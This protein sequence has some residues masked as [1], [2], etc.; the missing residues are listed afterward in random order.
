MQVVA[1]AHNAGAL[2]N[3]RIQYGLFTG[4]VT[5][6]LL[7][8]ESHYR[9]QVVCSY[10]TDDGDGDAIS[11]CMFSCQLTAEQRTEELL[12]LLAGRSAVRECMAISGSRAATSLLSA[13]LDE[14]AVKTMIRTADV[15][16][17]SIP[18]GFWVAA[19][20][21]MSLGCTFAL[22][23]SGF[24]ALNIFHSPVEPIWGVLGLYI[25]NGVAAACA[26][27][28]LIVW[29]ALF[30]VRLSSNVAVTDTLVAGAGAYVSDG[31][32]AMGY[33]YW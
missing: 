1:E 19:V 6:H 21:F 27:L 7:A 15:P 33:S 28:V 24:A 2:Q 3:S 13:Q 20:S 29:G 17:A 23:S 9:L 32:A 10:G 30:G 8:S 18:P 11:A 26:A 14:P 16:A 5:R 4:H 31:L 12:A 22:V 25:W